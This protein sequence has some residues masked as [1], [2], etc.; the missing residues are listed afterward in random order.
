LIDS[1]V[2]E[3]YP[4]YFPWDPLAMHIHTFLPSTSIIQKTSLREV[5]VGSLGVPSKSGVSQRVKNKSALM[6]L[7]IDAASRLS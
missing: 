5:L 4:V 7:L 1:T 6:T 2:L 3:K